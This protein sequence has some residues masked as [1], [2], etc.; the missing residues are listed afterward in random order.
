MSRTYVFGP[1]DPMDR[2]LCS[3]SGWAMWIGRPEPDNPGHDKRD[4]ERQSRKDQEPKP[5]NMNRPP[6]LTAPFMGE[7]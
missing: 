4:V 5:S 3:N 1:P 2:P 6:R 7:C